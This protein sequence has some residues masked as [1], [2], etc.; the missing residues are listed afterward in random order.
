MIKRIQKKI[1]FFGFLFLFISF[2]I[3][4]FGKIYKRGKKLAVE[5][6]S[7]KI[8]SEIKKA[9]Q[10]GQIR[11]DTLSVSFVPLK[12]K[13]TK[14][15]IRLPDHKLFPA[16]VKVH[17]LIVEPAYLTTLLS[18]KL[19][20]KITLVEPDIKMSTKGSVEKKYQYKHSVLYEFFAPY[21]YQS[22]YFK[23]N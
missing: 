20:V 16:P 6:I 3:F 5:Y 17:T 2:S 22:S 8:Q 7:E 19:S 13:V 15:Q 1:I 23:G 4:G 11:W 14:V 18:G 21:S 12:M 10:D 9:G